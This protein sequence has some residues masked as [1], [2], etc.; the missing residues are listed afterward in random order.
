TTADITLR[1]SRAAAPRRCRWRR[2]PGGGTLAGTGPTRPS[3]LTRPDR[4]ALPLDHPGR[5]RAREFL[6]L[7][8]ELPRPARGPEPGRAPLL[9]GAVP[10]R[11]R[12][13][14]PHPRHHRAEGA[15]VDL[16]PPRA[17]RAFVRRLPTGNE[18]EHESARHLPRRRRPRAGP[19][20][21]GI[22][23]PSA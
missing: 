2:P 6:H 12:R 17:A 19:G 14:R 15:D 11:R 23:A 22:V 7:R 1:A 4:H 9:D 21:R 13:P 16:A 18:P 20:P 8:G 10:G 3:T 5:R